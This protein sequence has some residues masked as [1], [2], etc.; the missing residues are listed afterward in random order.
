MM[1]TYA[2]WCLG[3]SMLATTMLSK[4]TLDTVVISCAVQFS[5]VMIIISSKASE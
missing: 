2:L 4:V 3:L 1:R 5:A